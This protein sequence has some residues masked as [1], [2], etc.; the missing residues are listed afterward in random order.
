MLGIA[1]FPGM[2]LVAGTELLLQGQSFVLFSLLLM[3]GRLALLAERLRMGRS[4]TLKLSPQAPGLD[5]PG[6]R[7]QQAS[8]DQLVGP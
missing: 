6:H 4:L 1:Q 5:L 7:H 8:T 2:M 3:Q